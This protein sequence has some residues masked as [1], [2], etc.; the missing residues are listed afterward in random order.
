MLLP[1][2]KA[3]KEDYG[4]IYKQ[5]E[6][7]FNENNICQWERNVDRTFSCVVN[8]INS[9]K[10]NFR[11]VEKDGCC[12]YICKHS[13]KF[14]DKVIRKNQHSSIKGCTVKSLK[15]KLHI[16]K[17]LRELNNLETI[18][19]IK[20]IDNLISVFRQK[21]D[22]LWECIPYGAS[23]KSCIDFYRMYR[24]IFR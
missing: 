19:A 23:K 18:E 9:Q 7:I 17:Y 10:N 24:N 2:L 21:Y 4:L 1:S 13:K 8:R 5:A 15:C 20:K 6:E 16:C 14:D 11:F 3:F 12:I 22:I